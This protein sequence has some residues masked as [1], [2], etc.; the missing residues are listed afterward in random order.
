MAEPCSDRKK[1]NQTE[2][3]TTHRFFLIRPTHNIGPDAIKALRHSSCVFL[4]DKSIISNTV[5]LATYYKK[6]QT[7]K[8]P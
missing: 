6:P 5:S 4:H 3:K 1:T 8:P 7:S 2:N